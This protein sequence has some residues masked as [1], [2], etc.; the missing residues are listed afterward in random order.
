M[1][2][3]LISPNHPSQTLCSSQFVRM[4]TS[5]DLSRPWRCADRGAAARAH[6]STLRGVL[7]ARTGLQGAAEV[8]DY[9]TSPGVSRAPRR[10]RERLIFYS[11]AR[12]PTRPTALGHVWSGPLSWR[13]LM[14]LYFLFRRNLSVGAACHRWYGFLAGAMDDGRLR[15]DSGRAQAAQ[16]PAAHA[17]P[18]HALKV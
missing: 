16:R 17:R 11:R 3:Q 4:R 8:V 2:H 18:G 12:V 10:P 5:P 13:G 6:R 7:A 14:L 9:L 1:R 15:G